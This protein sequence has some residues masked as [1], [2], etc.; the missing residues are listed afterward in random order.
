[1]AWPCF[2][3]EPTLR[4]QRFTRRYS[5]DGTAT[6]ACPHGQYHNAVE[7]LDVVTIERHEDAI[8]Y[9]DG[10]IP[11]DIRPS[12]KFPTQ[13]L[14]GYHFVEGDHEQYGFSVLMR[15]DRTGNEYTLRNVP[16]GAMWHAPWLRPFPEHNHAG[17]PKGPIIVRLPCGWDWNVDGPS[18]NGGYWTRTGSPPNLT[19]TPSILVPGYHGF[20]R[21]GS[22]TDPC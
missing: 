8:T 18:K 4:Y 14:C 2:L 13:C 16:V 11:A 22:L 17:D 6:P 9:C 19:V 20:L 15:D 21:D 7:V 5:K 1:M 12:L 10:A 3:I